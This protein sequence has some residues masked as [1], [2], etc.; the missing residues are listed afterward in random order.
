MPVTCGS[1]QGTAFYIGERRFLTAWHVVTEAD[2]LQELIKLSIEGESKFCRME[3]LEGMDAA[4]LTCMSDLPDITPIE[5]LKTDFRDDDLEIIGYPQELGNGVD[6]F[7]VCVKNLKELNDHSRGFDVMVLRTD[8]FGFH[9]YS[10]YSGSPVLNQKGVA[11]G[12]VTDQMYNTLGYT[13]IRSISEKLKEK[14]IPFLENADQY[15]M[16][17]VGIGKCMELAEAACNKM[18]SR[19]TK[20]NHVKDEELETQFEIFCGYETDRWAKQA[21]KKL[22]EWCKS[23]GPTIGAAVNKLNSL[24]AYR[25]GEDVDNYDLAVDMEFLLNKRESD[26]SDNYFVTGVFRD[27][28]LEISSLMD[29][30]Q[31]AEMLEGERFMYVHGD[32]GCGKTQHVCHFTENISKCR[33]VYLL[34]GTDFETDKTPEQS[35][36]DVLG[37]DDEHIFAVLNSEMEQRGRYATFIIDALNEGEGTFMWTT[38]LPALKAEIDRYPRLK[39]LVTVRTME[40]DD[41]LISQFKSGW[42]EIEIKGFS[43]MREAIEKY[44]RTTPIYENADDYLYVKEFQHPLF[45]KIFCQVFHRLPLQYRKEPDI[46]YLYWLY[47]QSRNNEVSRLA[48]EDPEQMVTPNIMKAIGYISWRQYQCCDVPRGEALKAANKMCPNRLWSNNLYHALVRSNLLMENRLKSGVKTSFQYDSMGDYVRAWCMQLSFEKEDD[49]LSQLVLM[50]NKIKNPATDSNA[51]KH[52]INTVKALLSVWNPS[53]DIWHRNEFMNGSLTLLLIESLKMRNMKATYSTLPENMVADLVL[54][55]NEFINPEYLLSNFALFRDFM[56]DPVHEKLMAMSMLERDEKWTLNVNR[57]QDDYSF[58][59][60]IRQMEIE[61]NEAN[62]RAYIRLLC[63]MTSSSHPQLRTHARRVVQGWLREYSQLC[64]ELIEKFYKC[65]DPYILRS[66]YSA[67]YGVLLVK[68]NNE[69]T[70]DVAETVYKNLYEGQILV[71]ND[72]E[73]RSWTLKILELNRLL[74]PKDIYW[75]G[76]KPPYQRDDNLMTISDGENYDDDAYFGDGNGAKKM[77]HS[78]FHW[79]FN[80][81]IIGTNSRNKSRTYFKDGVAVD[82]G[83]MTK[84]IAYRIKHVYGYSQALSDYDDGVKWE[85]RVHRQT[86]R[87]GKKYQWIAFGE[88]RAYLCDTCKMKKDWWGDKEPVETPYPWYDSKTVTFEPTL[89]MTGNRSYLDQEWFEEVEGDNLMEGEAHEWLKSREQVPNPIIVVKDKKGGEWVNIVG[90]QKKEQTENE[91]KR[92]SFVFLCPCMVR[93]EDANAFEQWTKNQCFYGR[94]MPE[95]SGH[96]EYFWNEFPWSDS[97][98]SLEFEEELGV[99]G[100]ETAA[101]C[102]VILPYASQLQEYYEEIDDEEEFEGMIYMPSAEMFEYFGWHTAER[103][104][105]R[106]DEDNVVALCRN[107]RGDIFDTMVMRRDL[108]NQYLE[109]KG[110]VLFYCMLAEKRLTQEPQQFFMQRLSSCIKYVQDGEPVVVQPMTDEEDFP[111]PEPIEDEDVIEGISTETWLQIEREGG[112]EKLRDLLKDYEKMIEE[113]KKRVNDNVN[114][115]K[116]EDLDENGDG[117]EEAEE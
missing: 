24:K 7:G 77:H 41:Q 58:R 42:K 40:Q 23:V 3:K 46:L 79:D 9:S 68:R 18:K 6:Y 57:M 108:L 113:K 69:L 70:H 80:R 35:I 72:I 10:G 96:Y 63:W 39:L 47:Y 104:V 112:D 59:F 73:C 2:S 29:D 26:K 60:K 114:N 76:A 82:L 75:D 62:A 106:D 33:N 85:E 102:K 25:D 50:S 51:R 81:Y 45:L 105:T 43:N 49:L 15:D 12:V 103:G 116:N 21:R 13:S 111:K 84:A 54:S 74:N 17:D 93:N 27:K 19:Y 66:V 36:R 78:L 99:Y 53:E 1:S 90:Y 71:P 56:L 44:F 100:H 94:W 11:I 55:K 97:Y 34:Y 65:D 115:N 38:L 32:A 20:E 5:L 98:K 28:L 61:S 8:P 87:M 86:E 4:L 14:H 83:E 91:D 67:V 109:A 110:M 52:L 88:V 89:T 64:K 37:W 22:S 117:T 16:R 30:A 31:N 107:L 48:D 95:D 101:P 92:E